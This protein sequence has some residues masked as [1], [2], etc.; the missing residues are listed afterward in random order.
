MSITGFNPSVVRAV[1]MG[2]LLLISK[3]IYRKN[4]I[5]T[6]I[7][8]SILCILIYNPFSILNTGV[9][10]SYGGVIGIT[11]FYKNI[12]EKFDRIR[13]KKI[14]YKYRIKKY[15]R[16]IRIIKEVLATSIS[17]QIM[18]LPIM[19]NTFNTLGLIFLITN[20]LLSLIIGPIIL[21]GFVTLIISIVFP[22]A[23]KLLLYLVVGILKQLILISELGKIIPFNTI[24]I[25]SLN[26]C[27]IIMYY[28]IIFFIMF[29]QRLYISKK[30]TSSEYR[31]RNIISLV[32]YIIRL[33]KSK[34]FYT[35]VLIIFILS[36]I[37][38]IPQKL[39]IH[40]IDVGQGDSTL[41]QTPMKK[42]ILIDGGGSDNYDVGKNTLLPYLLDKGI[43][44]VD[45]III[46][47]F[48]TDHIRTVF[49]M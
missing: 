47:H 42:S 4:D 14:K 29:V 3:V 44:R 8:I 23:L 33:N 45:Y 2:E 6:S 41:I 19:I 20:L 35:I 46:S 18:I 34:I 17:V 21:L 15:E 12:F 43:T 22:K 37:K 16:Q 24:Y 28:V 32:K 26:L 9:L 36:L 5:W 40:F 48:D 1:I 10:L 27:E 30:P 31:F 7:S 13:I 11:V 39:R 49:F 38:T 25:R